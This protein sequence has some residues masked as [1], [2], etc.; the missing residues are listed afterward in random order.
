MPTIEAPHAT[1]RITVVEH[2]LVKDA[3]RVLRQQDTQPAKFRHYA[4]MIGIILLLEM[5]KDLPTDL[6][7]I[8]T[9][10]EQT[11]GEKLI[12]DSLAFV[13]ILRAG[14]ALKF[15]DFFPKSPHGT[16]GIRRLEHEGARPELYMQN[17]GDDITDHD[18]I[19]F[20]PMLATGGS[21]CMALD[22]LRE[23]GVRNI[24]LGCVITAPEGEQAVFKAHPD[25]PIW[26]CA[27]DRELDENKFIRP[28]LGDFGDRYFGTKKKPKK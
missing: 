14:L 17:L 16:L 10:L 22:I 6:F 19:L 1:Q 15:F 5:T 23:Q 3:M 7:R 18:V 25:I 20:D 28:G 26:A 11:T 24:K 12:P 27:R 2:A 9:P 8:D 21:A 4:D 13:S